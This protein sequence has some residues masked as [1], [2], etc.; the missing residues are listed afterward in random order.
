[1]DAAAAWNW[2]VRRRQ[3]LFS[4]GGFAFDLA[5]L[6]RIDA[7]LDLGL[8]AFYLASISALIALQEAERLGR[9]KPSER[10]A[11]AW[12]FN[13]DALHFFYGG[14][15]SAY[16]VFYGKS[17]TGLGSMFFLGLVVSLMLANEMP[18]VQR[19]GRKLRLGLHAFCSLSFLN[20]LL[21]VL[22][23]RMGWWVFAL[24]LILAAGL[25]AALIAGLRRFSGSEE[26]P[27]ELGLPAGGMLALIAILY[28]MH[29]IPPVPLSLRYA[30]VFHEVRREGTEF[31]LRWEKP[32]FYAF[33]RKDERAFRSRAGDRIACFV[34]IFAPTRFTHKVYLHWQHK[35]GLRWL[36]SDR[37][38]LPVSGGRNDGYRG[39]AEKGRFHAGRWRVLVE[40]EDGRV[41]GKR[42]FKIVDDARTGERVWKTRLE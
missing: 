38:A 34:R 42:G 14:L 9:W 37:I 6:D 16:T 22:L 35:S 20:Y 8:Q 23:G 4:V 28:A 21:P 40:T 19:A 39:W 33:W 12:E 36:S 31:S 30:G 25:S 2:C 13:I 18:Q 27:I 41:I 32:P 1:M 29:W 10:W 24:A 3:V 26:R 7:W 15:L 17:T 5:T 11:R